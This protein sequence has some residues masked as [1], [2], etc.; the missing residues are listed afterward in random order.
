MATDFDAFQQPPV[1]ALMTCG[2]DSTKDQPVVLDEAL[3]ILSCQH[4]P[5]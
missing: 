4:R 3:A 2:A 5:L 1:T